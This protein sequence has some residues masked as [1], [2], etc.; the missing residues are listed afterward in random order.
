[1]TAPLDI[2]FLVEGTP[3]SK[4][5]MS[6]FPIARGK[7]TECKPGKSCRQRNCFGGV[8]V[9]VSVT[10]QGGKA[11]DAW[12]DLVHVRAMSA[13]NAAG[14]RPVQRPGALMLELVFVLARPDNHWT[15]RG[16]LSAAGR[17]VPDPTTKPDGDKLARAILDGCTRAL[18]ADDSQV[19][20]ASV[21]K[22][23]AGWRGWTGAVVNAKEV[24]GP[25]AWALAM[26][27]KHRVW[28]PPPPD[29]QRGLF[30]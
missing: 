1:M 16:D 28:T 6:G 9:G 14:A 25:P 15:K 3:L 23:F 22:V 30:T 10:D 20:V 2:S 4:G 13:R 18:V 17:A 19:I 21:A 24:S 27:E 26:L 29:P 7:C 11:L 8:L 12:E 5:S